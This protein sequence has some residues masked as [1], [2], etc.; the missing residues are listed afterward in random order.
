MK[1][2][3]LTIALA[4]CATTAAV[5]RADD[6]AGPPSVTVNYADLD[7]SQPHDVAALYE[8]LRAAGKTVCESLSRSPDLFGAYRSCVRTALTGAVAQ[9]D[10]PTLTA[11]ASSRG[12]SLPSH[13][14]RMARGN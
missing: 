8:R 5:A 7:I 14:V 10:A 6:S 2:L 13:T 3:M 1:P 11:Y 4:A 12:L 9:I